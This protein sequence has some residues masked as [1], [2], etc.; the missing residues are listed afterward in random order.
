MRLTLRALLT[1]AAL[2]TP[3]IAATAPAAAYPDRPVKIVVPFA[4]AGPTDVMARLI[5]QKLS[6]NL[7]QQFYVENHAG[8][9][10]NIGMS[11]VAQGGARRLHHSGRVIE[12]RGQSEPVREEPLRSLQGL[13]AGDARGGLAQR[14]GGARVDS[15]PRR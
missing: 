10:G 4:P 1:C 14:A 6:E 3:A 7:K 9:G 12:L 5:A 8:A 13:R 15:R 11:I 2:V